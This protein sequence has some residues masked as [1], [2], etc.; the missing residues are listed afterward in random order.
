MGPKPVIREKSDMSVPSPALQQLHGPRCR[1]RQDKN[2]T[3]P[4]L[5][6]VWPKREIRLGKSPERSQVSTT[7]TRAVGF[8]GIQL[9]SPPFPIPA[10]L[11]A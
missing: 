1:R 5:R 9:S 3:G 10:E 11:R 8:D 2:L 6:V 4:L 7:R